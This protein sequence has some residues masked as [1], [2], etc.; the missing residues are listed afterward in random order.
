MR[1]STA[2]PSGRPASMFLGRMFGSGSEA[3]PSV[4]EQHEPAETLAVG[5]ANGGRE[6]CK[7]SA[8]QAEAATRTEMRLRG[9]ID[10]LQAT[11]ETKD[12][13]LVILKEKLEDADQEMEVLKARLKILES[14]FISP[15]AA[16]V[17]D[18]DLRDML[19]GVMVPDRESYSHG[20]PMTSSGNAMQRQQSSGGVESIADSA[21]GSDHNPHSRPSSPVGRDATLWTRLSSFRKSPNANHVGGQQLTTLDGCCKGETIYEEEDYSESAVTQ[22]KL[23]NDAL[24]LEVARLNAALEDGLGALAE[25]GL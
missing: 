18:N 19:A 5:G 6:Q 13:T 15:G 2:A 24:K 16:D 8:A 14:S 25:L 11:I 1:R 9:Q 20:A 17:G 21:I 10:Q 23:E 7:W 3:A 4:A 12:L 22:L